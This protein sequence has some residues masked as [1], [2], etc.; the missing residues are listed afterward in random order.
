MPFRRAKAHRRPIGKAAAERGENEPSVH[1]NAMLPV[2]GGLQFDTRREARNTLGR[3]FH[4][5]AAARV[6]HSPGFPVRH[7]ERSETRN[8]HPVTP[9]QTGL[10]SL[11]YGVERPCRLCPRQTCIRGNFSYQI[12]FVHCV[13]RFIKARRQSQPVP[14]NFEGD[15][16]VESDFVKPSGPNR[17]RKMPC[18][19]LARL[20]LC[21]TNIFIGTRSAPKGRAG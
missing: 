10:N 20:A 21:L 4:G 3:H 17:W 2:E 7:P 18:V 19:S 14:L 5:A 1:V 6:P 15:F 16:V 12:F 11:Y 8:R 13:E 9:H